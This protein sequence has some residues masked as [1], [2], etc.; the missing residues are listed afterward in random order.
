MAGDLVAHAYLQLSAVAGVSWAPGFTRR[1]FF[2][3]CEDRGAWRSSVFDLPSGAGFVRYFRGLALE[4]SV[5]RAQT[6]R[7]KRKWR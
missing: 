1:G 7:R 5:K 2:F 6:W 3:F 4:H